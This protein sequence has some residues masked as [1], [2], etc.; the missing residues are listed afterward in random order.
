M[1]EH[2]SGENSK[3]LNSFK[4]PNLVGS[5]REYNYISICYWMIESYEILT[6]IQQYC[7]P[8]WPVPVMW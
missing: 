6:D 8:F 5:E 3:V 1:E 2:I 7:R 4:P